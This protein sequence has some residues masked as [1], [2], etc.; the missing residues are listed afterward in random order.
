MRK[1]YVVS[2]L[3]LSLIVILG[4]CTKLGGTDDDKE[5][6]VPINPVYSA[7]LDGYSFTPPEG[8]PGLISTNYSAQEIIDANY[9]GLFVNGEF[10]LNSGTK[11]VAD[12]VE[13]PISAFANA[14]GMPTGWDSNS[15][16]LTISDGDNIIYVDVDKTTVEL[17]G[18]SIELGK[19]PEII[20]DKIYATSEF[21]TK[22]FNA[23]VSFYNGNDTTATKMIP[24]LKHAMISRYPEDVAPLSKEVAMDLVKS[25]LIIAYEKRF[26]EYTP[27]EGDSNVSIQDPNY[28]SEKLREAI[29]DLRIT[30]ENDRFYIIPF[31]W[32]FWADKYTGEV[33]TFYNGLTMEIR[34]FNPYTKGALA[35]PG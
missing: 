22:V 35:F 32:D 1:K 24:R 28:E 6:T 7:S 17:N 14:M 34:L 10:V 3:L 33:Y 5:D 29:R 4:G 25:K 9:I 26:G 20:N 19:Y 12:R 18:E 8:G 31:V 16:I 21:Y 13:T 2:L 27:L 15:R 30:S 11:I 23:K